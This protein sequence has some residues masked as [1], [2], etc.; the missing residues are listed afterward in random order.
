MKISK[1]IL[2]AFLFLAGLFI[3]PANSNAATSCTTDPECLP[4]ER[5]DTVNYLCV[6]RSTTGA[7][8]C[9]THAECGAGKKCDFPNYVCVDDPVYVPTSCS[10]DTTCKVNLGEYCDLTTF[11]CK[12]R[13]T[14]GGTTGGTSGNKCPANTT[15]QNGICLPTG[16]PSTGL[17]GAKTL[18]ELIKMVVQGL[19]FFAGMIAVVFIVIGGYRYVTS[20]GNEEA[21]EKGRGTLTNAAI[22][23]II[24]IMAYA[25]VTVVSNAITSGP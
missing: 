22:G 4:T 24:I 15:L 1:L 16:G 2:I 9:T 23:L 17:A 20:G 21:A 10:D 3:G 8:S 14:T 12:T 18:P 19:L 25:I 5:C 11:T 7:I 6:P 13:G